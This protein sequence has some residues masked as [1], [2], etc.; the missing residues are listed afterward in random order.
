[1]AL[2]IVSDFLRVTKHQYKICVSSTNILQSEL[3]CNY[4]NEYGADGMI[5]YYDIDG[6]E[7][8]NFIISHFN[9]DPQC[10]WAT[11]I[12][13]CRIIKAL[14]DRNVDWYDYCE[15]TNTQ[16]DLGVLAS[17]STED[18]KLFRESDFI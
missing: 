16:D 17:V 13:L 1:M 8:Y 2:Y 11:N 9:I 5:C 18:P 3:L 7:S 4:K 10:G 12:P 14:N 6:G 15:Q